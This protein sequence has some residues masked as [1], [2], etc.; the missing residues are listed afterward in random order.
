MCLLVATVGAT[1]SPQTSQLIFSSA[2]VGDFCEARVAFEG[3]VGPAS[4]FK[5][6]RRIETPSGT[7]YAKSSDDV[8][9]FPNHLVIRVMAV[10]VSTPTTPTRKRLGQDSMTGLRFDGHWKHG[11]KLRPV[12][13]LTPEAHPPYYFSN[14]LSEGSTY[15]LD[16]D[17]V[18]VPLD[19][20]LIL[21]VL[22]RDNKRIARM[23]FSLKASKLNSN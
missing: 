21:D 1:S 13:N 14:E 15:Y 22:A 23:S 12:K 9:F 6:L 19:D 18:E 10:Q 11:V 2:A 3:M 20:H 8:T 4:F 5:D 17:D 7:K 16:I